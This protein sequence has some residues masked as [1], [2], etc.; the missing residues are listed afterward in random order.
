[1]ARRQGQ[2]RMLPDGRRAPPGAPRAAQ[3]AGYAR[4][5][6]VRP[7][8]LQEPAANTPKA[9]PVTPDAQLPARVS[10]RHKNVHELCRAADFPRVDVPDRA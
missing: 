5:A 7:G 9:P 8:V 3:S 10:G 4:N 2:A 6:D 1:M